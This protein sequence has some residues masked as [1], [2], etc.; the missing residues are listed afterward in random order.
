MATAAHGLDGALKLDHQAVACG[1]E[2]AAVM[3]QDE[4]RG[5]VAIGPKAGKSAILVLRHHARITCHVGR[6][7]GR[8]L[9]VPVLRVHGNRP[10]NGDA[11]GG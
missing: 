2:D 6:D 5:Y 9:S 7:N 3:L 11:N 1:A 10:A 8:Q 4:V